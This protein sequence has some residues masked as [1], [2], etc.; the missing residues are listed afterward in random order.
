MSNG[1]NRTPVPAKRGLVGLFYRLVYSAVG[2]L[3]GAAG[4]PQNRQMD[5][6]GSGLPQGM[7]HPGD[8]YRLV[9]RHGDSHVYRR[10]FYEI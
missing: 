9:H 6:P 3:G 5:Q 2:A 7:V 8:N 10:H 4:D 1:H